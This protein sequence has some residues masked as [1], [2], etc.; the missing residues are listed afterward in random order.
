MLRME[1]EEGF[2]GSVVTAACRERNPSVCIL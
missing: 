2:G 1:E